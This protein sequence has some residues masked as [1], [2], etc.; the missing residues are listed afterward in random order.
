MVFSLVFNALADC[1]ICLYICLLPGKNLPFGVMR[2]GTAVPYEGTFLLIGGAN[3][4][5]GFYDTVYKY[6]STDDWEL[7]PPKLSV[8]RGLTTAMLVLS[9]ICPCQLVSSASGKCV[10]PFTLD[11]HNYT[12]CIEG[13][14][15]RDKTPPWALLAVFLQ[16]FKVSYSLTYSKWCENFL[17]GS[18]SKCSLTCT[19]PK[20]SPRTANMASQRAMPI[21][22]SKR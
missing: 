21:V 8:A 2:S 19:Q 6:I 3:K 22:S 17:L 16:L 18:C 7:L 15:P 5:G 12:S 1:N 10:F 9:E 11:G 20:S 4:G 14:V 13:I